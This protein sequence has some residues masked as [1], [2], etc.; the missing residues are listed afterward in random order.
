MR[1]LMETLFHRDLDDQMGRQKKR[2]KC[3]WQQVNPMGF[4]SKQWTAV[5]SEVDLFILIDCPDATMSGTTVDV[6]I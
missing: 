4:I 1:C 6:A 2:A 5:D 3:W